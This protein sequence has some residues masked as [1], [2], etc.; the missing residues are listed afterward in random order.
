M[1]VG[2]L[3]VD[4][5]DDS[6]VALITKRYNAAESSEIRLNED[7]IYALEFIIKEIKRALEL[8]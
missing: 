8:P 5:F 3:D 1:R 6:K 2:S 7:D 4:I